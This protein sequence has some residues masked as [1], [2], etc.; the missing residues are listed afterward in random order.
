MT[1]APAILCIGEALIDMVPQDAGNGRTAFLPLPGGAVFNTAVA[2]ARLGARVAF[3]CGLSHDMF[4]EL[5]ADRLRADGIDIA[6]CPRSDRPTTLA[7]VTLTD[8]EARYSF[9][10][11]NTAGRMIT[12]ADLSPLG[13]DI[14][15]VFL[16]GIS[17]VSEPCG[18]TIETAVT[19]LAAEG[20]VV[21]LDPN[22]R[23]GFIRDETAY[24]DRLDRLFAIAHI[25]KLSVEDLEWLLGPVPV[26]EGAAH[27]LSRGPRVVLITA[28]AAGAHLHLSHGCTHVPCPAVTVA[29]TVGAGDTFNAGLLASLAGAGLLNV[30]ALGT[31]SPAGLAPHVEL[32]VHAASLSATRLGADPP[33]RA[34][35]TAFRRGLTG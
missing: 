10:D 26:A 35:L 19:G 32:A 1:G 27:L 22:I 2:A 28:G 24:R 34:E 7:F 8:G 3:C 20:R 13:D 31:L 14:G 4:G 23:P 33:R 30:A 18:T 16:G 11:E 15:A 21:M 12:P 25:V 5:L 6:P 17:L 29:D 9:Y